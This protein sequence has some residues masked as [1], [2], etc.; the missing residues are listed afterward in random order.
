MS[1]YIYWSICI[2]QVPTSIQIFVRNFKVVIYA[3]SIYTQ[4][5]T[6][7]YTIKHIKY[8]NYKLNIYWIMHN[9][10]PTIITVASSTIGQYRFT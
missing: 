7:L 4:N 10:N 2:L 1:I 9:D 3:L 5:T 8:Y 6:F